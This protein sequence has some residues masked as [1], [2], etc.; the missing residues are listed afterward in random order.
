MEAEL[1]KDGQVSII[2]L[3]DLLIEEAQNLRASDI[4]LLP[5]HSAV[6]VR[7]RVDGILRDAHFLPKNLQDG[8][9]SRIKILA[10]LRTDEHQSA[11]DGRFRL[12]LENKRT[13]DVRV[14]V[15][16][17][18]HGENAVLRLLSDNAE[19]FTLADLGFS[20]EN[21]L[22]LCKAIKRPHGIILITGPTGSGKTTTLYTLL[23]L[24]NNRET[25]IVTLEDPIEYAIEGIQQIQVN[26][27]TGLSFAN[28]LRGI[29][30][31][32]PNVIMV[33][34]IRDAETARL[35]INAAL[36]GHLVLSTLHTNDAATALP[37]LLDMGAEGYLLSSTV[38]VIV[39]QR[40]ARRICGAC[41]VQIPLTATQRKSLTGLLPVTDK[42]IFYKG[43]GCADCGNSGY[44]GR[45]GLSE[46]LSPNTAVREAVLVK[47]VAAKINTL[48][49][50]AGMISLA[51]D[52]LQKASEGLTSV[53]EVLRLLY[54]L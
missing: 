21:Q 32:D 22:L 53:D 28:G 6:R 40:L 31:Q 48:A 52:G 25:A 18:Y 47:A 1:R 19:D 54:E 43:S 38:N 8:I 49:N 14:C 5:E 9:I 24:L 34:E 12:R 41:K 36:T 7:L 27:R 37:R 13:V 3:I 39:G 11:Q 33:G 44:L 51:Q 46:V 29:L 42:K 4:H 17:T 20:A 50:K 35:A 2:K 23:K 45:V 26:P 10:G 30:R 16:P 15:V